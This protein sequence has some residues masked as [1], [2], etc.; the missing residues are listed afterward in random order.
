MRVVQISSDVLPVPPRY[1]GAIETYIWNI[2]KTLSAMGV[3]VH[4]LSINTDVKESSIII[5]DNIYLHTYHLRGV[6][7]ILTVPVANV[8]KNVTYLTFKLNKMLLDIAKTYG[9]IDVIHSHYPATAIAP[10]FLRGILRGK[11]RL[12]LSVHGEYAGNILDRITFSKYDTILAV[13]NFIKHHVMQKF[14]IPSEKIK[15]IHNAV[16]TKL[17]KYD[18]KGAD[19][20][21]KRLCLHGCPVPVSYTHLTLPT[22]REV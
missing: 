12:V 8:Y 21:K 17:F 6:A 2:S 10:I 13:S 18:E 7:K 5:N 15:V 3:E 14:N 20:I 19:E 9:S 1:G 11:M 4:I 16:N 22:N